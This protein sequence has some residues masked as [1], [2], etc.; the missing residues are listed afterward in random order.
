M[1]DQTKQFISRR[2]SDLR[3]ENDGLAIDVEM[4]RMKVTE[5]ERRIACHKGIIEGLTQVLEAAK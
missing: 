2:I 1:N 3:S 5:I 4:A